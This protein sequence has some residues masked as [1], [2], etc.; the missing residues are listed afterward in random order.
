M[1]TLVVHLLSSMRVV[2]VQNYLLDEQGRSPAC[3]LHFNSSV[4]P[5]LFDT[6][7]K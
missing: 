3:K 5:C 6:V 2:W 7:P 4:W 1:A